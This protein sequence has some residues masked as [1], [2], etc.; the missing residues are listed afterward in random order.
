MVFPSDVTDHAHSIEVN[1]RK[2]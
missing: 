2:Q 1:E